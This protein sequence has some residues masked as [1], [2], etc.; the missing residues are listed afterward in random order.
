MYDLTYMWNLKKPKTKLISTQN[1][2]VVARGRGWS[3]DDMGE[4]GQKV[5]TSGYKISKSWGYIKK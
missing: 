3:V 4:G 1:K 2:L 5:Q